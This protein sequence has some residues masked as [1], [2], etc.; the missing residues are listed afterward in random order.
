MDVDFRR[1]HSLR[2]PR[3]DVSVEF[4]TPNACTDCHLKPNVPTPLY[5]EQS[6][7]SPDLSPLYPGERVRVRG[8]P[9]DKEPAYADY[10]T[11]A[12]EGD[13]AVAN[14]L[15]QTDQW[16]DAACEK[17]YGTERKKPLHYGQTIAAFRRG[18]AGSA[19]PMLKLALQRDEL[20][21]FLA[22]AT[23]L[24]NLAA[25]GTN[26][27]AEVAI[28]ILADPSDHP[29]VRATAVRGL[30]TT[31]PATIKRELMP[32][33]SDPMRQVRMESAR[34]LATPEVYERL[35]A[36]ERTQ[37]DI[38]LREVEQS[39]DQ[40]AD[41]S[42]AHLSWAMLCEQRGLLPDAIASYEAAIRVEPNM[43]GAR[44]NLAALYEQIADR[45][46]DLR[47]AERAKVLRMQELP[48]L[49]RDAGLVPDNAAIQYRYGL[50]LYLTGDQSGALKQLELATRLAPNVEDYQTALMLLR[51]KLA[52]TTPPVP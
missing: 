50:A 18:D 11:A 26:G 46:H 17:W 39:I 42:G 32:R 13:E 45:G 15:K 3:P 24:D 16:C 1:D 48:L 47:A 31:S 28:R 36:N 27:C 6:V 25:A 44:T 37:V 9:A 2:I 41:R 8:F 34:M 14:L 43:A 40:V 49:R 33:L 10:L 35:T 20:T 19:E 38:A 4:G 5:S 52:E 23:A 12:A 30:A 21:P 7:S 51:Q 22:R 29:L